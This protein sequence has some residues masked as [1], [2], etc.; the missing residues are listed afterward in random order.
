MKLAQMER[1]A[2]R[3]EFKDRLAR[4]D[5]DNPSLSDDLAFLSS[6]HGP[7]KPWMDRLMREGPTNVSGG[8]MG[9]V[10]NP[11][12]VN[13]ATIT[14]SATEQALILPALTPIT[15][16]VQSGTTYVL[17]ASGTSTTAATP[18]T[19]TLTARLG[20][21]AVVGST[22][23]LGAV[24]GPFTP[25][26]SGTA[27]PWSLIGFITI[28]AGGS[29][30]N[31]AGAFVFNHAGNIVGAGGPD[32]S[33]ITVANT[34]SNGIIGGATAATWDSTV[35]AGSSLWVGV[36][37]ATSTT[38]TWIQQQHIWASIN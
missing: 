12:T 11:I 5:H 35:A 34:S 24:S 4:H 23:I 1:L 20:S 29:A 26:A 37:H 8:L 17:L 18:G 6:L 25:L 16:N 22:A 14:G 7:W 15:S 33:S 36:T 9:A 31:A 21:P 28:R 38:N 2:A 27:L 32:A 10:L 30:C 13:Q 19:Y 3:L